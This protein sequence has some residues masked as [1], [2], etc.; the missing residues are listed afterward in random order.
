MSIPDK[1]ELHID[2]LPQFFPPGEGNRMGIMTIYGKVGKREAAH[3][4]R[5]ILPS[6]HC[7]HGE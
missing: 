1:Y 2:D 4:V 3:L 7:A 6:L 5:E